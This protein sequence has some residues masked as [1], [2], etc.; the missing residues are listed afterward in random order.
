MSWVVIPKDGQSHVAFLFTFFW[1]KSLSYLLVLLLVTLP[2]DTAHMGD[3]YMK[4]FQ[5]PHTIASTSASGWPL[6]RGGCTDQDTVI[7]LLRVLY[8]QH[9]LQ[10]TRRGHLLLI[11]KVRML[12]GRIG[13]H[14]FLFGCESNYSYPMHI[15][16][17]A[18]ITFK[19]ELFLK[20]IGLTMLSI[21]FA[22]Q[23]V[24]DG[25]PIRTP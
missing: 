2:R 11:A 19:T 12:I 16:Q 17:S 5:Y 7:C 15:P 4:Q 24:H 14:V 13:M 8:P 20:G 10:Y 6:L 21:H 3:K 18:S 9:V 23:C 22:T 1:E 25:C